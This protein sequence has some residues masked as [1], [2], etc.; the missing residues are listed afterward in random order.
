MEKPTQQTNKQINNYNGKKNTKKKV[1]P[2]CER[3]M[4][5]LVDAGFAKKTA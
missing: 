2:A 4:V 5:G 3:G 1:I